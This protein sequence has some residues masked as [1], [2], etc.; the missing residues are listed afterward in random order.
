MIKGLS[1]DLRA[2]EAH[3]ADA[4]YKWIND[5]ETN[6]WRGLYHPTSREEAEKWIEGKRITEAKSLS[7]SIVT[8]QNK[9][10]IGFV[11]LNNICPRSRRAEFWIYIGSKDHWGNGFGEETTRALCD[12][13]FEQMNLHRIWLECNPSFTNVIRCYEKVGFLQEGILRDGYYRNGKYNDTCIMGL[14]RPDFKGGS[15]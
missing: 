6:Q 11:G 3:D 9:V 12:Y 15:I 1:V 10:H 5:E 7:L 8:K 14:L 4:Y 2:I 13:A